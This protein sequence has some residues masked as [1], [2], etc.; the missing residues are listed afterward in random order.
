MSTNNMFSQRYKKNVY[1]LVEKKNKQTKQPLTEARLRV[2]QNTT[3]NKYLMLMQI[4]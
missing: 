3:Q 1:F 4:S 2:C